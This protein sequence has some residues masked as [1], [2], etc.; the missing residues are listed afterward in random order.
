[1][2]KLKVA[3]VP[4]LRASGN[5][6]TVVRS[7]QDFVGRARELEEL[8]RLIPTSTSDAGSVAVIAGQVGIGKTR[9]AHEVARRAADAGAT[10]VWGRCWDEGA[11]RPYWPWVQIVRALRQGER[12]SD[13]AE[14]VLGVAGV[15]DRM[16]LFDATSQVIEDTA[17]RAPLVVVIDDLHHADAASV[18]LLRFVAD[19][20]TPLPVM[21]LATQRPLSD[22][23]PEVIIELDLLTRKVG[24]IELRGLG[25]DEVAD[26]IQDEPSALRVHAATGGNPLFVR[27]V[28]RLPE[29]DAVV[30]GSL[31]EVVRRRLDTL[32]D[33]TADVLSAMAVLGPDASIAAVADLVGAGDI[34]AQLSTAR[35]ADLVADDDD[36]GPQIAHAVIGEAALDRLDDRRRQ[37][38]HAAAATFLA[39]LDGRGSDVARHLLA[40]GPQHRAA[41]VEAARAA[42]MAASNTLASEDAADLLEAAI[43]ALVLENE[44]DERVHLELLLELG[45]HARRANRLRD[46][47]RAYDEAWDLALVVGDHQ[48]IARA[49]LRSGI[50]YYFSGD[51]DVTEVPRMRTALDALPSGPSVLR[52][53]LLANLSL[54]LIAVDPVA[55]RRAALDALAMAEQS[56]DRTTLGYVL[57]ADQISALGPATLSTRLETA[58]QM[59]AIAHDAAD[60]GLLVQGRF[61]LMGALL[62]HGDLRGL[63]HELA[64]QLKVLDTLGDVRAM[65]HSLWFRC[66][67]ALLDG[68]VADA[69]ELANECFQLSVELDDADGIGVLGGQLGIVRWIQGRLLEMEP[70]YLER[71]AAEP[72]EPLWSAVLAYV[73]AHHGRL[74]AARGAL[75][76]LPPL[77][78]IAEGQFWLLTM[79]THG[80]AAVIVGD[81]AGMEAVRDMLLPYADRVVPIAMGAALWGSVARLLGLISIALGQRDEGV[82]FLRRGVAVARRLGARPWLV[83]AQLDLAD[84]LGDVPEPDLDEIAQIL[85]EAAST[86]DD[87][88][89]Q[90][91]AA[92]AG[93]LRDRFEGHLSQ[94]SLDAAVQRRAPSVAVLGGLEVHSA[95]GELASWSSRKARQLLMILVAR[96]GSAIHREQLVELL[97]PDD[98]PDRTRNRLDVAISAVRRALDPDREFI[99]DELIESRAGLVRLREDVVRVD[100]E[101]FMQAARAALGAADTMATQDLLALA[102]GYRGEAFAEEPYADWAEPTRAA[103]ADVAAQL[104]RLVAARATGDNDHLTA[105]EAYR[106]LIELDR[107]DESAHLGLIDVL[108]RDGT[109]RVLERAR[110]SYESAMSALGVPTQ[111]ER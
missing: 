100:L 73:W 25:V 92:R 37:Q 58:R 65:R 21:I 89:L 30:D 45:N 11:T 12:G 71:R 69:E 55:S 109:S 50:R 74:D 97:W 31:R 86:A 106:R 105:V 77:D 64:A 53:R 42:A 34:D 7:M 84:A 88:G 52:A 2:R 60:S 61:L 111:H 93:R 75:A 102:N 104:Y 51:H 108:G 94:H 46:S 48:A 4:S 91:L 79:V 70:L 101:E 9:L 33:Q 80:E 38:Y 28:A 66:M 87:L 49:A 27:E 32:D 103:V 22:E 17:A 19:R 26:L 67:R 41:G 43:A 68:R 24:G 3:P 6:G 23:R 44:H 35:S 110:E 15:A 5:G 29:L 16:E 81:V 99:A 82:H 14:L 8:N 83:E 13:L 18:A 54:K 40:A 96:R 56:G 1:V 85:F 98:D 72:D 95:G 62:E 59:I 10:V 63:D 20:I 39:Q 90:V 107:Y 78:E 36:E 47:D 76:T 57:L